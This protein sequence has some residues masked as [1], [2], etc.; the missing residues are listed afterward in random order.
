MKPYEIRQLS[1]S[2]LTNRVVELR[3]EVYNLR[4]QKATRQ[5][6]DSKRISTLRREIAQIHTILREHQLG[7]RPLISADSQ[8]SE[9]SEQSG[10]QA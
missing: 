6:S 5:A 8:A 3:E 7:I 2:E 10:E 4:F 1:E 9:T